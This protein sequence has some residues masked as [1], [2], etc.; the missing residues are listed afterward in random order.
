M[1]NLKE[2]FPLSRYDELAIHQ[3]NEPV[4]LVATTDPR[5]FERYW[6]TAQDDEGAFF[7]IAGIGTYPN[8]GTVDAYAMIIQDG[9]QTTIRAHRPMGQDRTD[10]SAGPIRFEL[11]EPFREW[12][13]TLGDN[14]QGFTFDL[15]WLDT[16]RAMFQRV[17]DFQIPGV[18]DFRLLHNW[19]GYETFGRIAGTVTC[20]GKTFTVHAESTRGSRDHHWGTRDMV[21]GIALDSKMPFTHMD[22]PVGP[23]HL[24]QWVEFKEWSIWGGRVLYNLGDPHSG[25]TAIEQVEEKLRFDPVTKHLVGAVIVNRLPGGELREVT[26]EQIGRQCAYLR[27][28]M[29]PGCDG[30]GTPDSGLHHGN[31][32]GERVEGETYDLNDPEVRMRIAGFEDHLV[33]ATCNGETTVGILECQNPGIYAMASRGI[34]FSLLG[35]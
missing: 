3:S 23:S 30:R 24:G 35:D 13:L 28:G 17:G 12:R 5:A 10:L 20:R 15:R 29:Y 25:A 33:C 4:R 34:K 32:V 11:V 21:G 6:F 2:H 31:D 26:Y 18:I 14:A 9:K 8:L 1:T 19:A 22:Q 16:K 27:C 7:I